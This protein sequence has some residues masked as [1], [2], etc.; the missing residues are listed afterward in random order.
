MKDVIICH[1]LHYHFELML[2]GIIGS[3]NKVLLSANGS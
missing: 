2:W 1:Y 3:K